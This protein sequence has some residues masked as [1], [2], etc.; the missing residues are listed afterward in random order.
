[1]SKD[2]VIRGRV[3]RGVTRQTPS[4][5]G[6]PKPGSAEWY[7]LTQPVI[8]KLASQ[9]KGI[10]LRPAHNNAT[11]LLEPVDLGFVE[12][13]EFDPLTGD[14]T[15]TIRIPAENTSGQLTWF[16]YKQRHRMPGLS[17]SHTPDSLQ[18]V[19]VSFCEEPA[20]AGCYVDC[21]L[22]DPS[23]NAQPIGKSYS[24]L[25]V[26]S[27]LKLWQRPQRRQMAAERQAWLRWTHQTASHRS[28]VHPRCHSRSPRRRMR[29]KPMS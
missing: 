13:A 17:L 4:Y 5:K 27:L 8:S 24:C 21:E 10:P 25:V 3:A 20:R 15:A 18:P 19:E 1:M 14:C 16:H 2:V 23:Y 11:K 22:T 6:K 7:E 12:S 29:S 9:M 26:I 28:P